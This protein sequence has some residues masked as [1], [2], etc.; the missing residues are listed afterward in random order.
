MVGK[1]GVSKGKEKESKPAT[2]AGDGWRTSNCSKTDLQT[3]VDEC[4]L[5]PKEIIQWRSATS[6]ETI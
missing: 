6:D 5:Q 3:I 2:T 1:K 4:L